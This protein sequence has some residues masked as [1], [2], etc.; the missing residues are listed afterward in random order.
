MS[1]RPLS[2]AQVK[3]LLDEYRR[4]TTSQTDRT[5]IQEHL[6]ACTECSAELAAREALAVRL[7][8]AMPAAN[9][10]VHLSPAVLAAV[11]AARR[12]AENDAHPKK[13]SM[14][15]LMLATAVLLI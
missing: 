9:P 13:S 8:S 1:H 11:K 12:D 7:R 15:P 5:L 3:D 4:G 10:P 2:C 14:L 6:A